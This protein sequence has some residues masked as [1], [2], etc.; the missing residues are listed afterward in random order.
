MFSSFRFNQ[1]SIVEKS[2]PFLLITYIQMEPN[3]IFWEIFETEY[4]LM[5]K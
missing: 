1:F 2:K 4:M 5:V 3:P